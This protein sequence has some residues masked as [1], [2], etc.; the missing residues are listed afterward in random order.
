MS[1]LKDVRMKTR[2]AD[3]NED[4]RGKYLSGSADCLK[5]LRN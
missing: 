5:E 1:I 3:K 4:P 2:N